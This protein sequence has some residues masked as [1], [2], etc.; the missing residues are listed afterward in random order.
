MFTFNGPKNQKTTDS[1]E[2]K[3]ILYICKKKP[4]SVNK[5]TW[6]NEKMLLK[7]GASFWINLKN[8]FICRTFSKKY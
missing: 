2:N 5:L 8:N 4:E 7:D 3:I 6:D 1:L